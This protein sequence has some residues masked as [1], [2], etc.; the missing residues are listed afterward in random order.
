[1]YVVVTHNENNFLD[2][3]GVKEKQHKYNQNIRC[4]AHELKKKRYI[5]CDRLQMSCAKI[6]ILITLEWKGCAMIHIKQS[7]ECIGQWNWIDAKMPA[8]RTSMRYL[9]F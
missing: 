4:T 2:S 3:V 7:I 5:P 9:S 6:E 1:M 8:H